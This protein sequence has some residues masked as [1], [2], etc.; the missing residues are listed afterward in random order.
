MNSAT[1]VSHRT[2]MRK[3]KIFTLTESIIDRTH[4]RHYPKPP[5]RFTLIELLIV[6]AIIAI[7]AGI[8]LPA[9]Q[10][11]R[12]KSR[13]TACLSNISQIGKAASM[14]QSDYDGYVNAPSYGIKSGS[15][16]YHS[17]KQGYDKYMVKNWIANYNTLYAPVWNCPSN[18]APFVNKNSYKGWAGTNVSMIGNSDCLNSNSAP[19]K[20]PKVKNPSKK[21]LSFEASKV[22]KGGSLDTSATIRNNASNLMHSKHGKGSNFLLVAGNV[23]WADDHSPYRQVTQGA[24]SNTVWKPHL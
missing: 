24:Y 7:L 2:A 15:I 9:L 16:G 10:S 6:I 1:D 23:L 12:E 17:W 18:R 22:K 3:Q 5:A 8:L 20:V 14:Y 13:G 11:A 4:H 19:L 21:V